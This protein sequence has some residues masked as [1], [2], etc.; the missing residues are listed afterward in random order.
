MTITKAEQTARLKRNEE[1]WTPTLMEA[2]WTV[3]PSIILEKQNALGLDAIDV[4]ILLQL[5]R[6]W[7]YPDNPPHPSKA[8]IAKC[9]GVDPSTVRR[10]IARMEADGFIR[11][12]A[13][14]NPK[15]R[16]QETNI[17]HFDGLIK[18]ATPY[19]QEFIEQRQKQRLE[20]AARQSRKKP[21]PTTGTPVASEATIN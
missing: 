3:L 17:Y 8:S 15:L 1:K 6:Y 21:K 10:H 12:E 5:A 19:A 20:N 18:A 2:G 16:G 9:I 14:Y 13:R 11:R 7:W 4:N